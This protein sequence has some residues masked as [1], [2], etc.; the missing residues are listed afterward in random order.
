MV[1]RDP[2]QDESAE[3]TGP[4][5]AQVTKLG[6]GGLA[7]GLLPGPVVLNGEDR[8]DAEPR[9]LAAGPLQLPGEDVR[10]PG[11]LGQLRAFEPQDPRGPR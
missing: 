6:C 10:I 3:D 8:E 7:A 5:E 2:S 4:L 9:L 1:V 11:D